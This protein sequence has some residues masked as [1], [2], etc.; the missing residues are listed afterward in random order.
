M[1][2]NRDLGTED[3]QVDAGHRNL[4]FLLG[5][6]IDFV[7]GSGMPWFILSAVLATE[8]CFTGM[9][10]RKCWGLFWC[11]SQF[12]AVIAHRSGL[13]HREDLKTRLH[14]QSKAK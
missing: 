4:S 1:N 10:A 6:I 12:L 9:V 8:A 14:L 7:S 13:R 11:R 2:A 3:S 5:Y